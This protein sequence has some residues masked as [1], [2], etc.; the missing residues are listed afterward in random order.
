M[1]ETNL[2]FFSFF[3]L[4]LL[5]RPWRSWNND[6]TGL[7]LAGHCHFLADHARRLAFSLLQWALLRGHAM[8]GR[9]RILP[10]EHGYSSPLSFN[11]SVAPKLQ[12]VFQ[13]NALELRY[14]TTQH[15]GLFSLILILML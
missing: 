5:V 9:A 6:D 10:L 15:A 8:A 13:F 12:Q 2:L 7:S 14:E 3:V 11:F 4:S 1:M